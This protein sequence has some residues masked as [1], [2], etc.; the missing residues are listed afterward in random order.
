[1]VSIFR[2]F[3]A[4]SFCSFLWQVLMSSYD[5][6]YLLAM[7]SLWWQFYILDTIP[8]FS[9]FGCSPLMIFGIWIWSKVY[10]L[11]SIWPS[12]HMV[13]H[14]FL[15]IF[16]YAGKF[17]SASATNSSYFRSFYNYLSTKIFSAKS[18][19]SCLTIHV[20]LFFSICCELL[21]AP[22]NVI[23]KHVQGIY[24]K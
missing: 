11:A 2:L 15:W 24:P 4:T 22:S 14:Y 18:I 17:M 16:F 19:V 8:F 20:K 9:R 5:I 13:I 6:Y 21:I 1:M 7:S 23:G 12:W 3:F 10:V